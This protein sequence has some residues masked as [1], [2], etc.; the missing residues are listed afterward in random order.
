MYISKRPA[1]FQYINFLS[2]RF[3][4][5]LFSSDTITFRGIDVSHATYFSFSEQ[6][7]NHVTSNPSLC[8]LTT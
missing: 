8:I 4:L 6:F 1:K 2:S 5:S 7:Y 3:L